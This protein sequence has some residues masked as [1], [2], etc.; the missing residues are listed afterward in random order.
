MRKVC[1]FPVDQPQIAQLA[2]TQQT[3]PRE[4]SEDEGVL[5]LANKTKHPPSKSN[6]SERNASPSWRDLSQVYWQPPRNLSLPRAAFALT[7]RA[8]E[9]P[10]R[11]RIGQQDQRLFCLTSRVTDIVHRSFCRKVST[12]PSFSYRKLLLFLACLLWW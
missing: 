8:S 3:P 7:F 9:L 1:G 11:P 12:V 4:G 10:G 5:L 6:L 2:L